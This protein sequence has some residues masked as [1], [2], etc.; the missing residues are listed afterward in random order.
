M[1]VPSGDTGLE[2]ERFPHVWTARGMQDFCIDGIGQV[3]SC[4]RPSIVAL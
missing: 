3:Q 2:D 4:V 1:I